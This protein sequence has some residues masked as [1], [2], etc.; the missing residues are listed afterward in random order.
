MSGNYPVKGKRYLYE[1][2]NSAYIFELLGEMKR[3]I[4]NKGSQPTTVAII[5]GNNKFSNIA[6]SVE[7]DA[8]RVLNDDENTFNKE[9][10]P[11]EEK[12]TFYL[13]LDGNGNPIATTRILTVQN[14]TLDDVVKAFPQSQDDLTGLIGELDKDTPP[15]WDV[16]TVAVKSDLQGTDSSSLALAS[17]F[18]SVVYDSITN[19]ISIL[20]SVVN[21]HIN[22]RCIQ[23]GIHW[24]QLSKSIPEN[25]FYVNCD[26]NNAC[27]LNVGDL[28]DS[29]VGKI[30]SLRRKHKEEVLYS[31]YDLRQ[32]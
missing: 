12:S 30:L 20:T 2:P 28:S 4:G 11:Y 1:Q 5:P 13:A 8:F 24:S 17:L 32:R 18:S 10:G 19:G 29:I 9:Y 3:E 7:L 27:Y 22:R 14:K 31:I 6:R 25:F 16:A 26:N 21:E 23:V 15:V